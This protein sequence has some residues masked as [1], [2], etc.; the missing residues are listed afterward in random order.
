MMDTHP[1]STPPG[2]AARLLRLLPLAL[3]AFLTGCA[4]SGDFLL[5]PCSGPAYTPSNIYRP[6]ETLPVTLK[7]V[8]ILPV[9]IE[10]GHWMEEA[11][12]ETLEPIIR[13]EL[14]KVQL[15]ETIFVTPAQLRQWTGSPVLKASEPL[16]QDLYEII[17]K[18][19]GCEGLLFAH[20]RP[21]QPYKPMIIGWQLKLVEFRTPR[22]L[23]A[24]DEVFDAANPAVQAG[25]ERYWRDYS[26][27]SG[28]PGDAQAV[29]NSPRRFG[30]FTLASLLATLPGR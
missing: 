27:G 30:Q 3:A 15:F 29:L 23:W 22:V 5:Q 11:G 13:S 17:R 24:A 6:Q 16:P 25:A 21:F 4:T 8:A 18:T 20:L 19:T 28:F 9:S 2:A 7:R 14:G 1:R 26:R 10:S 12:L